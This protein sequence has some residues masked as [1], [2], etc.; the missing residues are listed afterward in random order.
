M[1]DFNKLTDKAQAA[2]AATQQLFEQYNHNALDNEH[3]LL[4]LIEQPQGVISGI[5][6]KLNKQPERVADK[7]KAELNKLP[8][9][10]GD[11]SRGHLSNRLNRAFAMAEQEAKRMKDEFIGVE[12][13]LIA[14][15]DDQDRGAAFQVLKEQGITRESIYQVLSSIRGKQRITGKNPEASYQSL[16]K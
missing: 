15:A 10:S 1:L 11:V 7:V 14:L 9:V 12:H 6:K 13:L 3:L 5:L 2:V 16:E 8:R 4:V